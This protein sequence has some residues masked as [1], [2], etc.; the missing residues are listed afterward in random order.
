MY[1]SLLHRG[2]VHWIKSH[3]VKVDGEER[4][5]E[6]ESEMSAELINALIPNDSRTY[7]ALIQTV[8]LFE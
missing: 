7:L 5:K 8:V 3:L 1:Y 6:K 4:R 2:K